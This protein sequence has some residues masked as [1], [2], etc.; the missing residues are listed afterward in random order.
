MQKRGDMVKHG[1]IPHSKKLSFIYSCVSAG[2]IKKD[3]MIAS[4]IS[5]TNIPQKT[6]GSN[7]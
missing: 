6:N 3:L 7:T 1:F 2:I 5:I 4:S